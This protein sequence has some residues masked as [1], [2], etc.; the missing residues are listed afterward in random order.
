MFNMN[1]NTNQNIKRIYVAKRIF[2]QNTKIL[3][4]TVVSKQIVVGC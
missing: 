3:N 2:Q 1:A 4:L